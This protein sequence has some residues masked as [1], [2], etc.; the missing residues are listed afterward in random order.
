MVVWRTPESTP[1]FHLTQCSQPPLQKTPL[2]LLLRKTQSPFVGDSGFD[3]SSKPPAKI[4]TRRMSEVV[5]REIAFFQ[6]GIDKRK[7]AAGPSRI[8]TATARFSST[9][10]EG[11]ALAS[12]S[13]N[14]TIWFQSVPAAFDALACT[15]AIAAWMVYGPT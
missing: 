9:T 2:R 14:A 3:H 7:P 15:A 4:R 10:G 6:D 1:L 13:Y 12:R 8:A 11:S 5:A